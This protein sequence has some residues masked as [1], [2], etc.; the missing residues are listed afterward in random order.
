MLKYLLNKQLYI[1]IKLKICKYFSAS[2]AWFLT[3]VP[4]KIKANF[5]CKSNYLI[6]DQYVKRQ[7]TEYKH[8]SQKTVSYHRIW[9]N[10]T[11]WST[12]CNTQFSQNEMLYWLRVE[13]HPWEKC[14]AESSMSKL[15]SWYS[16]R[17]I[18]RLFFSR[19]FD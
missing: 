1:L 10:I 9:N 14:W 4:K 17:Y 8:L 6:V 5:S 15:S 2:I 3:T 19:L 12:Q 18:W 16:S 7:A 13:K 11:E